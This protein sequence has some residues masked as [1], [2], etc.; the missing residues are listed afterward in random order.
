MQLLQC[1]YRHEM[2]MVTKN[3]RKINVHGHAESLSDCPKCGSGCFHPHT[4]IAR[5]KFKYIPLAP[6][7]KR[8]FANRNVSELLQT[9]G[10]ECANSMTSIE[11]LHQ[12]SMWKSMYSVNI[13]RVTH[14]EYALAS[15]LM[16]QTL[17][18]KK[19][20]VA[21]YPYTI[22][23]SKPPKVNSIGWNNSWED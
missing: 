15:A 8:M 19:F 10:G 21:Y 23:Y 12:T 11:D 5:E 1:L 9:H 7:I 13:L 6:R 2:L 14:V 20:N 3:R 4:S 22:S 17:F 16:A 18:R